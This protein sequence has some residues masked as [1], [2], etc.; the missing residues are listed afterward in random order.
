MKLDIP[1]FGDIIDIDNTAR[2][3]FAEMS[4]QGRTL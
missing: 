3:A 1:Q 4:L 2:G